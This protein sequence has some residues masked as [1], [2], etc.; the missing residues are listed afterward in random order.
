MIA[1]ALAV[2]SFVA[3]FSLNQ[4]LHNL[5]VARVNREAAMQR[6]RSA[7]PAKDIR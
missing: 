1:I 3:G 4:F 5:A 7:D 6:L 2:S